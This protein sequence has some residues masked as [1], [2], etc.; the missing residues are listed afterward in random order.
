MA[1]NASRFTLAAVL[2]LASVLLCPASDERLVY[3]A[4][5]LGFCVGE[6][7]LSLASSSTTVSVQS[8]AVRSKSAGR[9]FSSVDTEVRCVSSGVGADRV[10]EVA[11]RVDEGGFHQNDILR[12]WPGRGVAVWLDAESGVATTSR[13][14]VGVLD[15][16]SF[17]CDMGALV[18]L[19]ESAARHSSDSDCGGEAVSEHA[20]MD[21]GI[22]RKVVM[23]G[24]E[25]EVAF[26]PGEV[27]AFPTRWGRVEG[28]EFGIVSRSATLFS[29]NV[30]TYAVV[31]TNTPVLLA[32]DVRNSFGRVSFRLVEW[33][34]DGKAVSP[35]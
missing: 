21:E 7:V 29:R 9:L 33:T 10:C 31:A 4:R 12:L 8:V 19:L 30:P 24:L 25:H 18:R 15:F 26:T 14:D 22:V 32:L 5:K 23:D 35:F 11:K 20:D 2:A 6:M 1:L 28:R 27:V 16:A 13:V 17:F 3:E 34:R